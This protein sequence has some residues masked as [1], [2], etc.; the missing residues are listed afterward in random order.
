MLYTLIVVLKWVVQEK[1]R[2][3][4][5]HEGQVESEG[6]FQKGQRLKQQKSNF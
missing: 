5:H 3:Y 6:G 2:I 4:G 1:A